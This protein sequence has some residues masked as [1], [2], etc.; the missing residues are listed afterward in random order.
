MKTLPCQSICCP[1][2]NLGKFEGQISGQFGDGFGGRFTDGFGGR[3]GMS[4]HRFA[5]FVPLGLETLENVRIPFGT[6][7]EPAKFDKK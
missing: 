4:G 2:W 7:T 5:R 1:W 3:F 6:E